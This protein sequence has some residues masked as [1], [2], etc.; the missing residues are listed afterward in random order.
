MLN[1]GRR[2]IENS[3]RVG[4][5]QRRNTGD[6]DVQNRYSNLPR[7]PG[8]TCPSYGRM[9]LVASVRECRRRN[10]RMQETS[11]T[12][13]RRP[14]GFRERRAT[15]GDDWQSLCKEIEVELL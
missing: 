6:D 8:R 14:N 11:W 12:C 13:F 15:P 9:E 5:K 2:G 1:D 10:G 3:G 7:N 4:W